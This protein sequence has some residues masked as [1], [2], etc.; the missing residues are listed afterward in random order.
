MSYEKD[1][2][3]GLIYRIFQA[4]EYTWGV[5]KKKPSYEEIVKTITELESSAYEVKGTAE[6]G[7]IR[8]VY[9]KCCQEYEYFLNLGTAEGY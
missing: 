5:E 1:K 4:E 6:S 9:D 7:R 8:V 2:I 3:V